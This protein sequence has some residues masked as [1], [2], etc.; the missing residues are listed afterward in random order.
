MSSIFPERI[1][2]PP[3]RLRIDRAETGEEARWRHHSRAVPG[4]TSPD[5]HHHAPSSAANPEFA[6]FRPADHGENET[7]EWFQTVEP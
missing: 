5:P 1:A 6:S 4:V 7:P 2:E 3:I